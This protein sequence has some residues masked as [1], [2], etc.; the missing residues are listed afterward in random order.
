MI[1]LNII[2]A[3]C[4]EPFTYES[5]RKTPRRHCTMKCKNAADRQANPEKI[6][7]QSRA[8]YQRTKKP[9]TKYSLTATCEH[10]AEEFTH[11]SWTTNPN[12]FC[13]KKCVQA[14]HYEANKSAYIARARENR[15]KP[16]YQQKRKEYEANNKDRLLERR[17][18]WRD[19]NAESLREYY[20]NYYATNKDARRAYWAEWASEPE[21]RRRIRESSRA[22]AADNPEKIREYRA[23]RRALLVAA[24]V[25]RF[26]PYE[27]FERD[28]WIC[29]L[30]GDSVDKDLK[31]PELM[32]RSLDHIVPLTRGGEHS[33]ANTQLTHF[34]CNARKNNRLEEELDAA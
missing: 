2:C 31:F 3:N 10:C 14:S 27:V 4:A 33:R 28:Q 25:E 20:R 6:K 15:T 5:Q 23:S 18:A 13:S 26:D 16:E 8:S 11:E 9:A 34:L 19:A 29:Q 30:C 32:S 24:T 7:A 17:A 12:R 21:N 1:H 22:W